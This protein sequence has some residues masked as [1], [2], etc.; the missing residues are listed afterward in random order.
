MRTR[1]RFADG[2]RYGMGSRG[3]ISMRTRHRTKGS[4]VTLSPEDL[5]ALESGS[6]GVIHRRARISAV[7]KN[8][9][10]LRPLRVQSVVVQSG[11]CDDYRAGR[12]AAG[13][14]SISDGRRPCADEGNP[15]SRQPPRRLRPATTARVARSI[16]PRDLAPCC[17]KGATLVKL[18]MPSPRTDPVRRNRGACKTTRRRGGI[19]AVVLT[20]GWGVAPAIRARAISPAIALDHALCGRA[21]RRPSRTAA[22]RACGRRRPRLRSAFAHD[23]GDHGGSGVRRRDRTSLARAAARD[24]RAGAE[25]ARLVVVIGAI[26]C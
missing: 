20:A 2:T 10:A 4:H 5:E 24:R 18:A 14:S 26:S 21:P 19:A 17:S 12:P 22:T 13:S 16:R 1:T 11:A 9:G 6:A 25:K 3:L 23:G 7:R 8:Y 15:C